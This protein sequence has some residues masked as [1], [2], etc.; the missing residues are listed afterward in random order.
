MHGP[1][2]RVIV[3]YPGPSLVRAQSLFVKKSSRR[4]NVLLVVSAEP[5][6]TA[7]SCST[8]F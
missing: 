1:N 8:G 6:K 7:C 3:G 2:E 4:K 5:P